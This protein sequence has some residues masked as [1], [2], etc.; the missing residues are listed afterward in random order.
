MGII[1]KEYAVPPISLVN[2]FLPNPIEKS[3]TPTPSHR[4]AKKC[5]SSCIRI[6][7]PMAAMEIKTD[8][9]Q[10]LFRVVRGYYLLHGAGH[11]VLN[12]RQYFSLHGRYLFHNGFAFRR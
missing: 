8:M 4:A 12:S 9:L 7:R 1:D 6:N 10:F 3:V 2:I 11:F 5:P